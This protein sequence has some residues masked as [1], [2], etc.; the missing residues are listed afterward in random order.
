M[1]IINLDLL[2]S[3]R[4]SIL[5]DGGDRL[6]D[7][8]QAADV[9]QSELLLLNSVTPTH[10]FVMGI[11]IFLVIYF[12]LENNICFIP[13]EKI[14][15]AISF[16]HQLCM[17]ILLLRNQLKPV[18]YYTFIEPISWKMRQALNLITI[19]MNCS[20]ME[21]D[22]PDVEHTV[23]DG[24]ESYSIGT[25]PSES[26]NQFSSTDDNRCV[27][28]VTADE[29]FS[30]YLSESLSGYFQTSILESPEQVIQFS[31]CRKPDVIIVDEDINGIHGDEF[32]SRIKTDVAMSDIPVILLVDADDNE[33]YMSHMESGADRLEWR[34]TDICQFRT[35]ICMLINSH[36]FLHKRLC[37]SLRNAS[38]SVIT[39]P[40]SQMTNNFILL[41]K[42][43]ESLEKN[44]SV[45]RYTIKM[46]CADVGMSRSALYSKIKEIA[47]CP[48]EDY[49]LAFKMERAK[50]LLTFKENNVT[51]VAIMLGFN[52][53]KYFSKKFKGYFN[54]PPS[55]YAKKKSK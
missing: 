37:L 48:P 41:N 50:E 43:Q 21:Y 18:L 14:K 9:I 4:P 2:L 5:F 6:A 54:M 47:G 7:G 42:L 31:I 32:C 34:T 22:N 44:I 13:R 29:Q 49:I 17:P 20:Y 35:D 40:V 55:D 19:P 10:G 1:K 51:D 28:L 12:K 30:D 52:N 15:F 39:K 16:I 3:F 23:A 36:R 26:S 24:N 25:Y 33:S 8:T 46:L 53:S 45:E 11:S 27:L 38:S